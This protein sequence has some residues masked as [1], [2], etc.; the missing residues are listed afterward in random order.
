MA[1]WSKIYKGI[2]EFAQFIPIFFIYLHL[3]IQNVEKAQ[4]LLF[5]TQVAFGPLMHILIHINPIGIFEG[6][7]EPQDMNRFEKY[8][9]G[10]MN[11]PP[12]SF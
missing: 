11:H 1:K 6:F 8:L 9:H 2:V 4:F 7:A 12:F 3:D 5:P 10:A